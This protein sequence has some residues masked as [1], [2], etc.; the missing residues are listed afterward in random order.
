M[1]YIRLVGLAEMLFIVALRNAKVHKNAGIVHCRLCF[2]YE[3]A[4]V[5][6]LIPCLLLHPVSYCCMFSSLLLM[7]RCCA[8][9]RGC[10]SPP[11]CI[12]F[13]SLL[14]MLRC[15]SGTRRCSSPPSTPPLN[16]ERCWES[17]TSLSR[18]ARQPRHDQVIRS[19][20]RSHGQV[21][22]SH[23]LVKPGYID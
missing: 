13:S 5:T 14:L 10:S 23:E 17:R 16:D 15:S 18:E 21:T 20:E 3:L 2:I 11:Y 1:L 9:T 19:H 12:M 22:P 4:I 6:N 7:L 8:G